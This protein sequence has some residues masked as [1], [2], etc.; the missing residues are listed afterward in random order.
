[1]ICRSNTGIIL[2]FNGATIRWYSKRQNTIESSTFGSEF[3]AL[4]IAAE[5]NDAMRYKLCM[6]G[7]PI[8]EP[9]NTFCDNNSVVINVTTPESTRQKKL[10][11][12]NFGA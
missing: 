4:K 5:M 10:V 7:I 6:L 2:F 8:Q 1:M 9:T 11:C 3:I 12:S